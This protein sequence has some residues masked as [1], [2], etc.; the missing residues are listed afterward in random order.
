MPGKLIAFLAV[1]SLFA[2]CYFSGASRSG[3]LASGIAR[4]TLNQSTA[5]NVPLPLGNTLTIVNL[6]DE[7]STGCPTGNRFD[8]MERLSSSRT[9]GITMLLIFSDKHF[10]DQDLGN[11]KAILP[12]PDSLVR[13]DIEPIRPHLTSGK[14]LV[15]LDAKGSVLWQEEPNTSEQQVFIEISKLINSANKKL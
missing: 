8:T 2:G 11:F 12:M 14:L 1:T 10:S 7:F 9:A 6:F 3:E 13:G 5:D 4:V 15:V